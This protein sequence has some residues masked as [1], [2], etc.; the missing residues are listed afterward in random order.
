MWNNTLTQIFENSKQILV[1]KVKE[2]IQSFDF[3][4]KTCL[5]TC[6]SKEGIGYLLEQY[7]DYPTSLDP[8]SRY[9]PTEGEMF[10]VAWSS[11]YA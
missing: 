11:D 6:W 8:D 10:A 9:S 3:T 5:Q 7:C 2:G 1:N 4:Q